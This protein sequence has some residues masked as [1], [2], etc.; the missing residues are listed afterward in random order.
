[1]FFVKIQFMGSGTEAGQVL[2]LLIVAMMM[3]IN[4]V[5]I[6]LA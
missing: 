6:D 3:S 5:S 4:I 1:M 2:R